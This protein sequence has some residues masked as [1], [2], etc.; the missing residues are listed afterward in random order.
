MAQPMPENVTYR[1]STY[2]KLAKGET[3]IT[4]VSSRRLDAATALT[5]ILDDLPEDAWDVSHG[6]SDGDWHKVTLTIDWAK[7]P[8]SVRKPKFPT[9][10]G[11]RI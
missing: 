5:W 10:N 9:R 2:Y 6:G 7:V 4:N 1:V 8:D 3:G 11:R